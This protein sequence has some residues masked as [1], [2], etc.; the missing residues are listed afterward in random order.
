M[1][2]IIE[3][4]LESIEASMKKLSKISFYENDIL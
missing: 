2:R 1:I 3:K 4:A